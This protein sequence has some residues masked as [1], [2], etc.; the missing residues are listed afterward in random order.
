MTVRQDKSRYVQHRAKLAIGRLEQ[1]TTGDPELTQAWSRLDEKMFRQVKVGQPAPDFELKDT[2]GKTWRLSSFKNKKTV[3]LIWIFADWCGV[4]QREFHHLIETE[5]QFKQSN[6]QVLTI[7]CHDRYR[8]K[9]MV[10]DRDLWWP[11][12]VDIAGVIGATYGVDPMEFVVHDEWVNR[13]AT[14]IVDTKGIV[15]FAYYGTYWGDRPSIKQTLEM[16]KTNSYIFSH[17]KRRE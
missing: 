12:L 14:I 2:D 3:A 11:H 4:C 15:R 16:I 10:G 9:V 5:E 6:I 8:S 13:P 7:E 17:P 1:G